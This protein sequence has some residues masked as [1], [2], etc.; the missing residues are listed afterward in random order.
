M[1]VWHSKLTKKTSFVNWQVSVRFIDN[2]AGAYFLLDHSVYLNRMNT[3]NTVNKSSSLFNIRIKQ[4]G[5]GVLS[6]TQISHFTH[7]ESKKLNSKHWWLESF[8]FGSPSSGVQAAWLLLEAAVET[9]IVDDVEHSGEKG[10]CAAGDRH[11]EAPVEVDLGGFSPVDVHGQQRLG[12]VLVPRPTTKR[13]NRSRLDADY[14]T[15]TRFKAFLFWDS[16]I[17]RTG[18]CRTGKWRTKSQGWNNVV[19]QEKT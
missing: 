19:Q 15:A 12:V 16:W 10:Q 1:L 6:Y 17:C 2:S 18:I 3:L 9:A 7:V 8:N 11:P 5:V 14:S 4:A 13:R